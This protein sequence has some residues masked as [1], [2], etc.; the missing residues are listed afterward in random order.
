MMC[1]KGKDL[2]LKE[3]LTDNCPQLQSST[4]RLA[5]CATVNIGE[6]CI[7]SCPPSS[8]SSGGGTTT[9]QV[10]N[11]CPQ[12]SFDVYIRIDCNMM[13][14]SNAIPPVSVGVDSSPSTA[15]AAAAGINKS[16]LLT[17]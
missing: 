13:V 1:T 5:G 9:S 10:L 16:T 4:N 8:S 3:I 17:P 11:N 6:L 7:G 12:L 2:C 15:A 14:D